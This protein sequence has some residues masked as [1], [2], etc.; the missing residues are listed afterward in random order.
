MIYKLCYVD[1]NE[2]WFTSDWKHQWGDDWDDRPYEHNAER[3]YDCYYD[4]QHVE[5]PIKLKKVYFDI[6]EGIVKEPSFG[7]A[8]SPYSVQDIN[9]N[10]VAW[11]TIDQ[12]DGNPTY[13]FAGTS[14]SEFVRKIEKLGG[15]VYVPKKKGVK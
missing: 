5:H 6:P 11:L 9:N 2:V 1:G 14:Y 3:P 15:T 12:Y 4:K 10:R 13:I 8:N 7:L